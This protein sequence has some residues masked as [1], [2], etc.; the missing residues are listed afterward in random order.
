MLAEHGVELGDV[1]AELVAL[2]ERVLVVVG[3]LEHEGLNL[4]AVV[5]AHHGLEALLPGRVA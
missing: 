4:A 3:D 5:A 1:L 2:T